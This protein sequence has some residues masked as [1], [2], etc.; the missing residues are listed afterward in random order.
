V[1]KAVPLPALRRRTVRCLGALG[2]AVAATAIGV[3]AGCAALLVSAWRMA[4]LVVAVA[5]GGCATLPGPTAPP[6]PSMALAS[7]DVGATRLAALA[8]GAAP[9][10]GS[11][12]AGFRWLV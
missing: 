1:N 5:L 9:S 4:M 8:R 3:L 10:D 11:G 7:K 6:P 12:Q 2:T